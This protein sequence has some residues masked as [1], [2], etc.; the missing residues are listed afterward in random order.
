M[1]LKALIQKYSISG[2][3][4][5]SYP[6]AP[7]WSEAVGETAHRK[8]LA[9]ADA[10]FPFALYVHIPFCESLC[11]YCGCNIHL[12]HDHSMGARY[13]EAV[14]HEIETVARLISGRPAV[15]Q[16]AWGGGTPTFLSPEQIRRLFSAFREV[17][18]FEPEAEVSL[19]VDP[20]VTTDAHFVELRS[21]GF[22]RLSL[23]VQDFDPVVQKAINRIQTSEMTLKTL[24]RCRLLGFGGMNYDLIY[25]LPHQSLQ[26]FAATVDEVI[27]HSPD[28]IA[29]YNYAH[30]PSLRPH[31]KALERFPRPEAD[32][33]TQLFE[34]AYQRFLE[35]GYV[36]IGMDHFAKPS[37]ELALALSRRSLYRNFQGYTVKRGLPLLGFGAS[38]ISEFQDGYFQNVREVKV[39][40]ERIAS[41]G[42]A[43]L[44]GC[45][46]SES[47]LRRKWIIQRLMCRLGFDFAEY[48]EEFG[49]SFSNLYATETA[50]LIPLIG[51][52]LLVRNDHSLRVTDTGR[53]FVRNAA[54]VF[55]DYLL[56]ESKATYS[57]TL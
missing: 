4:Y 9:R 55:D 14:I 16:M 20:R 56:G 51:D 31:Q 48:E 29:L 10:R 23:G 35:A 37:D 34:M 15:S 8:A 3:R 17:F 27:R 39:Y 1:D 7:Q 12:T 41:T 33:R 49:E 47:D 24:E 19:E 13:C 11:L 6:T 46:L 54:M 40:E 43:T 52:G 18:D 25:G 57:K 28:R 45:Q 30:L 42:L 38:A 53:L 50:Q 26:T 5:T 2:P 22:N 21:L 44:R 32:V 36:S